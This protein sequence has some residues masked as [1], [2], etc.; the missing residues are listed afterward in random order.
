MS[1]PLTCATR[2]RARLSKRRR[3]DRSRLRGGFK[4]AEREL[5][6]ERRDKEERLAVAAK[7]Q[8]ERDDA[9]AHA[10]RE[11]EGRLRAAESAAAS[12]AE[13]VERLNAAVLMLRSEVA[14]AGVGSNEASE[15]I[16]RL[17]DEL[18]AAGESVAA[19]KAEAADYKS[20]ADDTEKESLFFLA[21]WWR[22]PARR[23]KSS[24]LHKTVAPRTT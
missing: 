2:R 20:K 12:G 19:A 18:A 6:S 7:I 24:R 8:A 14:N 3:S 10:T 9:A 16:A 11:L 21:R 23:R 15:K 22:L 5:H 17:E 13:E 4:A 1:R